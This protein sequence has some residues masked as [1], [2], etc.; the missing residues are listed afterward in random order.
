ML[1]RFGPGA[2]TVRAWT[3]TIREEDGIMCFRDEYFRADDAIHNHDD[4]LI[5][6]SV[7]TLRLLYLHSLLQLLSLLQLI[8]DP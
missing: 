8:I 6:L 3:V 7:T 5:Y 4:I 1:G 2:P